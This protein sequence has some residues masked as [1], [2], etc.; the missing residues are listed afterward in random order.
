M[1]T[2][3]EFLDSLTNA[4]AVFAALKIENV[5]LKKQITLREAE[6]QELKKQLGQTLDIGSIRYAD[7]R[8]M[9]VEVTILVEE[10]R[11]LEAKIDEQ[12]VIFGIERAMYEKECETRV[13]VAEEGRLAAEKMLRMAKDSGD[14][15]KEKEQ[16]KCGV[17][18]AMAEH[19]WGERF[20][21]VEETN[22]ELEE[23]IH[24]LEEQL[25]MKEEEENKSKKKIDELHSELYREREKGLNKDNEIRILTEKRDTLV[26]TIEQLQVEISDMT[27]VLGDKNSYVEL[28]N[29]DLRQLQEELTELEKRITSFSLRRKKGKK[30]RLI[31]RMRKTIQKRI[32]SFF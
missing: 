15:V 17:E 16:V 5:L 27:K 28:R 23:K 13:M 10:N 1:E 20:E 21:R 25:R 7:F 22:T 29:I 32:D 30:L 19:E 12:Q 8:N 24:A 3:G 11:D 6:Y 2:I 9:Q 18:M 14:D 31:E 4:S 26:K